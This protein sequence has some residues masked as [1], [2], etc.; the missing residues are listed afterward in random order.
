MF[1]GA[2]FSGKMVWTTTFMACEFL[3]IAF[4]FSLTFDS[5]LHVL[6]VAFVLLEFTNFL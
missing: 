4:A 1:K 5:V 3:A 6:D 2:A